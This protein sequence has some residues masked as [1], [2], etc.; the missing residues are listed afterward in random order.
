MGLKQFFKDVKRT[1]RDIADIYENEPVGMFKWLTFA[2]W[3]VALTIAY[4]IAHIFPDKD[5]E[6]KK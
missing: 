5:K 3:Y 1:S 4:G 2:F 6:D